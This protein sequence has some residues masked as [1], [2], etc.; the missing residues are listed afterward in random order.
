[1]ACSK[2]KEFLTYLSGKEDQCNLIYPGG[3]IVVRSTTQ[4]K[5][6]LLLVHYKIKFLKTEK[7]LT[8]DYLI[9]TWLQWK[10]LYMMNPATLDNEIEPSK[11]GFIF[12][13]ISNRDLFP[14]SL[15]AG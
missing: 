12:V 4:L 1:M 5:A 7:M 14:N 3:L 6:T 15:E 13:E 9:I 10:P 11:N 2:I 8:P